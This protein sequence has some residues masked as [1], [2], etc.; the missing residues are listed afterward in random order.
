MFTILKKQTFCS[1]SASKDEHC[2]IFFFYIY[3]LKKAKVSVYVFYGAPK[4]Y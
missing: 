2:I 3:S 1:N 4:L